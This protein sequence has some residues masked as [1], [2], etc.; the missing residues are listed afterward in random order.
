MKDIP[1]RLLEVAH[2][3]NPGELFQ[4]SWTLVKAHRSTL[5]LPLMYISLLVEVFLALVSGGKVYSPEMIGNL[6]GNPFAFIGENLSF[7]FIQ[8]LLSGFFWLAYRETILHGICRPVLNV[9]KTYLRGVVSF[10]IDAFITAFIFFL[11]LFCCFIFA[12]PI[13]GWWFPA[14][15]CALEGKTSLFEAFQVSKDRMRAKHPEST[16]AKTSWGKWIVAVNGFQ[17]VQLPIQITLGLALGF[18]IAF[19]MDSFPDEKTILFIGVF[20]FRYIQIFVSLFFLQWNIALLALAFT[21]G[22]LLREGYDLMEAL[23]DV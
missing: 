7:L 21:H 13:A 15:F 17:L 23:P 2:I 8:V 14:P 19:L 5:I 6:Q 9:W 16:L 10:I 3:R 18:G 12:F 4:G 22:E 11:G 20:I 1:L